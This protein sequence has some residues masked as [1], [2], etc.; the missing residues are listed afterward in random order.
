[1]RFAPLMLGFVFVLSCRCFAH[2]ENLLGSFLPPRANSESTPETTAPPGMAWIP[3]GEFSMGAGE[4]P[5]SRNHEQHSSSDAQPIHRVRVGGFWMDC[6][7]VTNEQFA[8]FVAATG[9]VTVAERPPDGLAFI[10][11]GKTP[12]GANVFDPSSES[13]SMDD[14]HQWWRYQPGADW[15][16]PEGPQSTI[17]GKEHLPVVQVAYAD[18]LAF[19]AWSGKRLPTEAEWEFAA[20]GGLTGQPYAWGAS[21]KPNGKWMAN[22]FQ[23]SFP[24]KDT[25][26]DG[27]AG[28]APVGKYPANGYGLYDMSGNVWQW[29]SDWYRADYY[30]DLMKQGVVSPNPG[31]PPDSLD[32]E[33]PTVPKRVQRGGSFLCCD[34]YCGRYLVGRRGKS[35]PNTPSNHVGFRCVMNPKSTD[36]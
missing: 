30:R 32:P 20:R 15:R 12:G 35:D 4:T 9:Y 2:Q 28:V 3:G 19:A 16:H 31:G 7:T 29:C 36:Q 5:G 24:G 22:I 17:A 33:E 21:L 27:F 34:Q 13:T 23:G 18:A 11:A 26:E 10:P 8:Q 14:F 1:M 6:T 25:G